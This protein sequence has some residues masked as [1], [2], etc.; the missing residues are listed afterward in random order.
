MECTAHTV[1]A[2]D[3]FKAVLADI[4]RFVDMAVNDERAVKAIEKK[5]TE[6]DRSKA[7][8]LEKRK[9]NKRLMELDRLF[10]ALYEDKVMERIMERNFDMM[11][12]KYQNEQLEVE[13]RLKEVSE[14]LTES[15]EKSQGIQDFLSL[16][17]NY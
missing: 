17:R 11:S 9:L 8:T 1:E 12:E 15:Y 10:S 7:R 14:M 3:L 2:R 16:I 6:T 13:T 5:L 4:N